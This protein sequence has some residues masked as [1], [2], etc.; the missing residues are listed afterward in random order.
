LKNYLK[1]FFFSLSLKDITN[2][3]QQEEA[4]STSIQSNNYSSIPETSTNS[5]IINSYLQTVSEVPETTAKNS[6]MLSNFFQLFG[7]SPP[8]LYKESLLMNNDTKETNPNIDIDEPI[9]LSE[10]ISIIFINIFYFE[11]K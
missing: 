3:N 8:R 2:S 6:G 4:T 1:I 5:S 9:V 7:V 10:S 11:K